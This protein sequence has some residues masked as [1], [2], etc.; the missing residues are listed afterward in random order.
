[1]VVGAATRSV[2]ECLRVGKDDL[3]TLTSYLDGRFLV[4][5]P[6][7]FA[8]LDRNVRI[9]LKE[10]L[11]RRLSGGGEAPSFAVLL[12]RYV[13]PDGWAEFEVLPDFFQSEATS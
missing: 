5:D 3:S 10:Y 8:E 2:S 6:A 12:D 11:Q 9:H 4:G 1:M 7:L 13:D